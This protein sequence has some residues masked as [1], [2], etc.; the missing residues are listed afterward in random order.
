MSFHEQCDYCLAKHI[1]D[2]IY[3]VYKPDIGTRLEKFLPPMFLLDH[4]IEDHGDHSETRPSSIHQLIR[5]GTSLHQH[6]LS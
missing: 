4:P 5:E 6:Q 2:S 3:K 1:D